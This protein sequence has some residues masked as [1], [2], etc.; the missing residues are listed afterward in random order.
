MSSFDH[1]AE[2]NRTGIGRWIVRRTALRQVATLRAF[3]PDRSC[4]ILEIGPGTG[5]LAETFLRAGYDNYVAVEPNTLMRDRLLAK[6]ITVRDYSIP[7]LLEEEGSHDAIVIIN[8]FE[9]LDSA[10]E[11][12]AFIADAR[13]VLRPDG[14]LCIGSPDYLHWR[15]DFFNCDFSHNYV[16]TVRRTL[17]IFHNYGFRTEGYFYYSAFLTGLLATFASH[18]ARLALFFSPSNGIDKKLYKLK[19]TFLRRFLIIGRKQP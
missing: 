5:E 7:Q 19:L 8:V 15:Q 12:Q 1:Y 2:P 14:I 3:L 11:A 17:Q 18:L 13:R 6:K 16:T 4:A 9:H 10:K